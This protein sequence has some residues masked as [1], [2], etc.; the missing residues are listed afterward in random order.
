MATLNVGQCRQAI[1][2]DPLGLLVKASQDKIHME[3]YVPLHPSVIS[4]LRPLFDGKTD[5]EP[6]FKY[7]SIQ[8]WVKR[9]EIPM[10]WFQRHFVL[11]DLRKFAEQHG[12]VIG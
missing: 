1:E 7:N 3:H 10:S 9:G 4:S 11:G 12:D 5:E 8:M 6:L 2:S